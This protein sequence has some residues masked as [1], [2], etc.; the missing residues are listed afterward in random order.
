MPQVQIHPL[1]LLVNIKRT[2]HGPMQLSNHVINSFIFPCPFTPTMQPCTV[3][4][5]SDGC[6]YCQGAWVRAFDEHPHTTLPRLFH[7]RLTTQ[8]RPA[9]N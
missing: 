1:D 7:F 4:P 8:R 5:L 3:Y 9:G 6:Q 2:L